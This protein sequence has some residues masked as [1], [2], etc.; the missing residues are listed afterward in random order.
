MDKILITAFEPFGGEKINSTEKVLNFLPEKIGNLEIIKL[1]LPVVRNK[2][3]CKIKDKIMEEKPKYI[4]SLGQ[5]GGSKNIAIERIGINVDDYRIKD[6]AGNQPI[7][8]KIFC[9]GENAHFSTLPIKKIYEKLENKGYSVK[10]SNT[11]GTFVCNHVLYG[12][13]YMI[14]KEKL[15]IKSGFI[16]IPYIDEQVKDDNTFSMSIKDILNAIICA[17]EV[18]ENY[19]KD[20]KIVAGEIF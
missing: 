5:A 12:I 18:I 16:H 15:D 20:E 14:E 10:I 19:E 3:L 8:E 6:N 1:L 7:D 2:S 13:R 9:D 17:I 4:L 11:A